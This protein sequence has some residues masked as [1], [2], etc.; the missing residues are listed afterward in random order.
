VVFE[1]I[2]LHLPMRVGVDLIGYTQWRFLPLIQIGAVLGPHAL[3]GLVM[4]WGASLAE[5]SSGQRT[6][7]PRNNLSVA[8]LLVLAVS[9]YGTVAL[10]HRADSDWHGPE[11]AE[12]RDEGFRIEVL[13][14]DID[15]Y[16]KWDA[17]F[18]GEIRASIDG[19]LA[20]PHAQEPDL[21][22]WPES[23]LPGWLDETRNTVWVGAWASKLKTHMLVGSVTRLG[24]KRHNSAVLITPTGEPAGVYHKRQLVPFGEFVPFRS[25]LSRFIGILG[26]M[27]DF[28]AGRKSQTLF[29]IGSGLF[30]ANLCYEAVFPHLLRPDAQA[31]ARMFVNLT[32]DG[33][34]KDT[35]GPYQHFYTNMFRAVENRVSVVRA[36]NTGI[37]GVIDPWGVIVAQTPLMERTRMDVSIPRRD[38]FPSGSFFSRHGDL[39]GPFCFLLLIFLGSNRSTR[40]R[41]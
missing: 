1:S 11:S 3:G 29:D 34:Y 2:S 36:A 10:S 13:Q 8:G 24:K 14:P 31:G 15:Q 39:L 26:Q 37:S 38:P 17:D 4:L 27:G 32:N 7:T 35:A 21:V 18:E 16:R 22:V 40:K 25:V 9:L 12:L 19:L 20:K 28:D 6:W 33:W 30:A 23:A 5:I 41:A